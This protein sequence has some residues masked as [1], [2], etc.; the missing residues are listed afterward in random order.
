VSEGALQI[1]RA[2][3]EKVR[4]ETQGDVQYRSADLNYLGL[5]P[6][7]YDLVVVKGTLHH[8]MRLDD[9]IDQI[10]RTLKPGGLLWVNDADGD[11]A[12]L[13]VLI[14]SG[15]TFLLPTQVSYGEKL[16]GLLR[17]GLR[18]PSRVKASMQAEGSSPFE[19]A[20]REHDWLAL[21]HQ[22]FSIE[23]EARMPAFTGYLTAQLR[24]PDALALP[25]LRLIRAG[26][27]L[28]VRARVLHS[29]G[30]VLYA[31]KN[32]KG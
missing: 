16:R 12:F 28:L 29:S 22:H 10:A 21:V 1:A 19:G 25:L 11:E 5:P 15:F 13:T 17:F 24:L 27:R 20:G 4:A 6:E 9:I 26:D 7:T 32:T 3:F 2:Y 18:S 31:R 8:L 23:A 14:A 30:V